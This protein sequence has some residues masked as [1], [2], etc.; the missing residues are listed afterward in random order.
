[1]KVS[2]VATVK[3]AGPYV[4]EFL[5][6]VA[7]QTRSPDETVVVD[8]GST[9]GTLEALREADGLTLI[10]EPGANIAR[11]RNLA[12]RAAAH[13][14]IA[15]SDADCV[16]EPD[17]LERLIEP[18]EQGADVSMGVY[19]P[20]ARTFFEACA[21]AISIREPEEVRE[22]TFMPSARSL[23]FRREAFERAGG[24][25]EW[26]ELGEDMY[27]NH[28][29]RELG[30]RMDLARGAVV[31]RRPRPT[32]SAYWRQF[33][34]YA[35]HDAVGGMHTGRHAIRFAVYGGLAAAVAS[36]RR[37]LLGLAAAAAAAY[38]ACP[39][40]RAWRR[41][42][43]AGDRLGAAVAIPA[44]MAVTDLAKMAGYLRGLGSGR[45]GSSMPP[46]VS[47]RSGH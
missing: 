14:A 6:S 13:D 41:M 45:T 32:L 31:H 10:E 46:P 21:A 27:V 47:D 40:R 15:V 35:E 39:I 17:W 11:G 12:V 3:D 16:L 20:L 38:A 37:G 25:P 23:A 36:R 18:L 1:M 28:R 22:D 19:R 44:L 2:L 4:G 5:A 42:P 9:D 33:A 29:W 24:Y 30:V 26:M 7:A 43:S 34:G 8:G